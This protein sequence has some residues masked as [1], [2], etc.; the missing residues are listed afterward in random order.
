L[1]DH[2]KLKIT[3]AD[4]NSEID[5]VFIRDFVVP[6]LSEVYNSLDKIEALGYVRQET[7]KT[8]L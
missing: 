5:V 4:K 1:R 2:G 3:E 6:Y 7:V 8:Y